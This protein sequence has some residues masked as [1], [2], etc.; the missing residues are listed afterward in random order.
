MLELH[1]K[2]NFIDLILKGAPTVRMATFAPS[3]HPPMLCEHTHAMITDGGDT[4]AG[5]ICS[6][7]FDTDD[8]L[9]TFDDCMIVNSGGANSGRNTQVCIF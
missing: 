7:S 9:P 6:E 2:I 3:K 5:G 1:S 8:G 4:T